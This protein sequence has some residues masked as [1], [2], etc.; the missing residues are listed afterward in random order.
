MF[1]A[2]G[3]PTGTPSWMAPSLGRS[4][5][6]PWG[7]A[8]RRL[9][10]LV[11]IKAGLAAATGA[12]LGARLV[13]GDPLSV[14]FLSVICLQVT[15]RAGWK[16]GA[17]QVG[18]ALLGG[19]LGLAAYATLGPLGLGP[20]VAVASW[21]A[22]RRQDPAMLAGTAFS[23]LYL[24][25]MPPP[26]DLSLLAQR[27]AAVA[28]GIGVA[29]VYNGLAMPLLHAWDVA[30]R[31]EWAVKA[32]LPTW[33][34][35]SQA[36][37]REDPSAVGA[38]IAQRAKSF[39]ALVSAEQALADLAS[40]QDPDAVL[41]HG[42]AHALLLAHE[43]LVALGRAAQRALGQGP[44]GPPRLAW[45]TVASEAVEAAAEIAEAFALPELLGPRE[46]ERLMAWRER[47]RGVDMAWPAPDNPADRLGPGLAM[48]VATQGLIEALLAQA[49]AEAMLGEPPGRALLA[50]S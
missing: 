39:Q 23:A 6:A 29:Q 33:R 36:L 21:P 5:E 16:A 37:H 3:M 11:A 18:S 20:A 28:V 40:G 19:L 42:R 38:A 41:G 35:I 31:R 4:A 1:G 45:P 2:S 12:W 7:A 47:L 49:E 27:M 15:T 8:N 25:L 10:R 50:P 30:A 43:G 48:L 32:I 44:V 17:E 26:H 13:P 24:P 34:A 22:F 9:A 46:V 14:A